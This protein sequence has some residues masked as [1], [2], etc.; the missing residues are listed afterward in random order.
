[1]QLMTGVVPRLQQLSREGE[2]GRN[3]INQ[4]TRYLTRAAGHPAV[5][6]ATWRCCRRRRTTSS[7]DF[8]L[9]SF[10]TLTADHHPD[11]RHRPADVDRRAHHRAR[12]RQRHQ[13]HH[14]R[15]H[16]GRPAW[17]REH[18]HGL[19][20]PG[21]RSSLSAC[22][23]SRPWPSSSTSRKASAAS[24]SSTPA[25]SAAGACTR[26]APRS[27]PCAS[28]RPASSP[29]SSPSASCSSRCSWRPTSAAP[30]ASSRTRPTS[31]SSG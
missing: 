25:A 3:K 15:R 16:R 9:T 8:D 1:M 30:A 29:S 18:V 14:L 4:Y 7:P 21:R 24:P 27:C 2:Y 12:H 28:T 23:A 6:T 10:T 5:A 19:P 13:L 22:S 31:S 17:R 11:G 26:V 20:G